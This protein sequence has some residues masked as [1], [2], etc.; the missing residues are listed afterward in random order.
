[1][2]SISGCSSF[3]G[4][5][6]YTK[7]SEYGY[8]YISDSLKHFLRYRG[9]GRSLD[10]SGRALI[11]GFLCLPPVLDDLYYPP[12]PETNELIFKN[13]ALKLCRGSFSYNIGYIAG[14]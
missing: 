2:L 11:F 8:G 13:L 9:G 4:M 1:M 3:M 10:S 12:P 5:K 14:L 7:C 6:S